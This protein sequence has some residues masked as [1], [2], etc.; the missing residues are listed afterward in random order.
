MKLTTYLFFTFWTA[1]ILIY[2]A[3]PTVATNRSEHVFWTRGKL[4]LS[5]FAASVMS[6]LEI[7]LHDI[8][9]D[10][11]SIFHLLFFGLLLFF[12]A[13]FYR[14]QQN[15]DETDYVKQMSEAAHKDLLISHALLEHSNN[16]NVRTIATN[17]V[18]RR[19]RDIHVFQKLLAD[20]QKP[21]TMPITQ[22]KLEVP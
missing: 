19:N 4:Y 2:W 10:S 20:L 22:Y 5:L 9:H 21:S 14:T 7:V 12:S 15:I 11:V 1:F 16:M 18:D 8:F 17:I 3:I 6:L 13:H